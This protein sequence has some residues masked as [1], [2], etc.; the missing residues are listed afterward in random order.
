MASLTASRFVRSFLP[1]FG[2]RAVAQGRLH[3]IPFAALLDSLVTSRPRHGQ[4]P[5]PRHDVDLVFL[6]EFRSS[7]RSVRV[8]L[9]FLHRNLPDFGQGTF[10]HRHAA[11]RNTDRASVRAQCVCRRTIAVAGRTRCW[12][13]YC[14]PRCRLPSPSI[15][16]LIIH[17]SFTERAAG[18]SRQWTKSCSFSTSR[19][20]AQRD[21]RHVVPLP[22]R[23]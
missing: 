21:T 20:P 18:P 19:K 13:S 22:A 11:H 9:A 15:R 17:Q 12:R 5:F 1:T 7:V 4:A 8:P 3:Q 23:H 10:W 2:F 6:A 14:V 16:I